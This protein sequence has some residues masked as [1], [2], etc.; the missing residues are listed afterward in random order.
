MNKLHDAH[1]S[2]NSS[3]LHNLDLLRGVFIFL[4][5]YQ[6][7]TVYVNYWFVYYFKEQS[8]LSD[9]YAA[10]EGMIGV[11]I[12]ADD[13]S[14][15]FAWFFTT[16]VSQIYLTLAA[17][18]L[19]T[20]TQE[21]FKQVFSSKLK[22]FA[23]LYFFFL[24]ESFVVSPNLGFAL[25]IS[26]IMTWMLVLSLISILFRF[27]GT[28]AVVCLLLLS[29]S[30]WLTP[31]GFSLSLD[32][33]IWMQ[34][35]I[36]PDFEYDARL[37]Y[38]LTSG[39]LGFLLGRFF[40]ANSQ[41]TK[42]LPL[43]IGLGAL[44]TLPWIFLEGSY[45]I[46]RL[47]FFETEHDLAKTFMGS[48]Y[49]YGVQ[50]FIIPFFLLLEKRGIVL[51]V[52]FF[53]WLGVNSIIVFAFHRIYFVFMAGPLWAYTMAVIYEAPLKHNS[54]VIWFLIACCAG[55]CWLTQKTKLFD[56]ITRAKG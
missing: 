14:V 40:Y 15:S 8:F 10:F 26:P 25:S 9:F 44:L 43:V 55:I 54:F 37:E 21:Q 2:T 41:S 29:F 52:P 28:K 23:L 17:F 56:L 45:Q 34:H 5:L 33:E 22:I 12:P 18:N 31:A 19:S 4:A 47:D 27:A 13:L 49:I 20:R 38:F 30:R 42:W 53:T 50:L 36:H 39:C 1:Q 16:W 46:D 24:M 11:R 6:H 48:L 32:F 3:R 35:W 7:F 51:K